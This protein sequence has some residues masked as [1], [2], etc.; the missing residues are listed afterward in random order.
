MASPSI[1]NIGGVAPLLLIIAL[2]CMPSGI[3]GG[4]LFVPVLR[5]IGGLQLKE[6]TALSQ[7][8]IAS[9][10]LA[11]TLFNCFEQYSA[12]NDPKALI[13]WPF[14][15]LTLPCTVIGSLIGVYLYSWLPSLFILILYFCFVCLGSF[16]AYRKGIRLWKAENGAKRR[17]VDGDS[18]DMSRSS[19]V[20]VEVPS[21]LRMPNMKKLAAYTSIAALIWAVCLIF[22]LLTG[23]HPLQVVFDLS[24][25]LCDE[26]QDDVAATPSG[27][28][29]VP[30][31]EEAFWG[32]AALQALILL[33]IPTGYVVAKRT[34][35]TARVGL[36]LMT[37]MIVIGLISSIVGI[38]GGLFMIPVV[39]SLGLDPKQA[40]ATTSI[41][42]FATSTST[43]LSFALGGYFP[44]ASDL[45]IVV[46]PFIGA[47]LGKTIVARLIA[48]TG[49]MSILVLLLG[50]VVIIGGITTI[51]TGIVSVVNGALNGDEVVQ[52]GSFC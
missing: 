11:A 52:F 10:S 23:T 7:A 35:E 31:C 51:S 39:L 9:A 8:L 3:G 25:S 36:V 41:V 32:L 47:L 13:V 16:M 33:L 17:A 30:F 40:T 24:P 44:P 12:R 2:L 49:R 28:I 27:V 29:G 21:L 50:T 19:E 14:V 46:M 1:E 42:I 37:S 15:I 18:T 38:S 22:P 6:S 34:A 4:V 20:T 26:Q 5:L 43:A 48:K 45:W